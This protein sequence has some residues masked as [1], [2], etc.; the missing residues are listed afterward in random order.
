MSNANH[1]GDRNDMVVG[2]ND[3]DF[4][5]IKF[6]GKVQ[7]TGTEQVLMRCIDRLAN[8]GVEM[9]DDYEKQIEQLRA[10]RDKAIEER[11][12]ARRQVCEFEIVNMKCAH[13]Y[14]NYRGWDCYEI[15]EKTP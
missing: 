7:P 9:F 13:D 15:K 11:D 1:I 5:D 14:A 4:A 10:E 8:E 3:H 2:D 12:E 6:K